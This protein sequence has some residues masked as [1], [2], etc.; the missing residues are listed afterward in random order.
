MSYG[1]LVLA[2]GLS[3]YMLTAIRFE[4]KDLIALFGDRYVVYRTEVGMLLPRF[5]RRNVTPAE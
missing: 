5:G 1:H 3:I 2:I 4:E